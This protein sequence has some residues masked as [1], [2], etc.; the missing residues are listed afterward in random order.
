MQLSRDLDVMF[1]R[2]QRACAA[3]NSGDF[4]GAYQQSR[5]LLSFILNQVKPNGDRVYSLACGS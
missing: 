4:A 3:A 2:A 1:D 5:G